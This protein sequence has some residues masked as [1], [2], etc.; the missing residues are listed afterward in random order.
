LLKQAENQA[1]RNIVLGSIAAISLL[2][3][4]IG[5]MNIMLAT[6]R[7]HPRNQDSSRAEHAATSYRNSSLRHNAFRC[8]G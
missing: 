1:H 5:I 8:R 3:G 2:V 7:T 6:S 4:G